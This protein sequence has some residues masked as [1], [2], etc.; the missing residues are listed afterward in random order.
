MVNQN[1][2]F[3]KHLKVIMLNISKWR[4]VRF[5]NRLLLNVI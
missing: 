2:M 1:P 5:E 3:G 4:I